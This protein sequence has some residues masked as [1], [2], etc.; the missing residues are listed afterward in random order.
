MSGAGDAVDRARLVEQRPLFSFVNMENLQPYSGRQS[1]AGNKATGSGDCAGESPQKTVRV[2]DA[3]GL[4]SVHLV[5]RVPFLGKV[6]GGAAQRQFDVVRL[7]VRAQRLAIGQ[8]VPHPENSCGR[9]ANVCSAP[10]QP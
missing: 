7:V 8:K 2:K 3:C 6:K 4:L 9:G 5:E 1:R 10:G